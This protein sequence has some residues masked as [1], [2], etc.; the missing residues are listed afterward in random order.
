MNTGT[1]EG[2]WGKEGE[3]A[4]QGSVSIEY[5]SRSVCLSACLSLSPKALPLAPDPLASASKTA[6]AVVFLFWHSCFSFVIINM[7]SA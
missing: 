5:Y 6:S 2:L 7:A 4:R 3:Q 1:S